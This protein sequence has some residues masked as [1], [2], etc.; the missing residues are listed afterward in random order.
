MACTA[1]ALSALARVLNL[2][3]LYFGGEQV[4]TGRNLENQKGFWER[5]DVRTLNDTILYNANCDWDCISAFRVD[6]LPSERIDDYRAAM[7]DIVM[8]MDAHR[9]MVPQGAQILP[10]VPGLASG[11]RGCPSASTSTAIPS[12]WPIR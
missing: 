11:S 5:R 3:G 6:E 4:S 12:K 9:P 7:A 2:M 10:A 8:D 1:P